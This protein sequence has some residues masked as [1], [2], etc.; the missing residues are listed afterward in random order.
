MLTVMGVLALGVV[1]LVPLACD[2]CS[3]I[4][5]CGAAEG[6]PYLAI[7]GQ[8][9]DAASGDGVEGVRVTVVRRG[10]IT[11]ARD[12]VSTVTANGGHW[13]VQFSPATA[14][15]HARKISSAARSSS[16]G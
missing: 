5:Q 7:D 6:S 9:V 12:S 14:G 3:G 2:P 8:I 16:S 15:W 13:R 1:G 4:A 10:G 11:V